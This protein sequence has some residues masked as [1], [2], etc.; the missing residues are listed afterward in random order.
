MDADGKYTDEFSFKGDMWSL[1][2]V[3]YYL[4]YSR[5]PYSQIEDVD[6]LRQEIRQ[7]KTITIP[8]DDGPGGRVI[9]DELKFLIRILVS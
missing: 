7:F 8:E 5:L 9:P 2:M 6:I 4:C 1:G 3:L